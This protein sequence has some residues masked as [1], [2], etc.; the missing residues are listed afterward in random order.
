VLRGT[1]RA[2]DVVARLGGE[3]FA[4]L[5]RDVDIDQAGDLRTRTPK[6]G[7]QRGAVNRGRNRARHG[8][9]RPDA[10][11]EGLPIDEAFRLADAALYRAKHNGRNQ[12][13]IA[14]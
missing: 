8:Q 2:G 3:E 10:L 7:R 14:A 9:R 13:S 1:V 4:V 6:I 12:L 5:L 11:D